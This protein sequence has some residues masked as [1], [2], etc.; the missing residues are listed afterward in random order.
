MK[1]LGV[2]TFTFVIVVLFCA[3]TL[4]ADITVDEN[5]SLQDAI[6]AANTDAEVGGCPA[7]DGADL[8]ALSADIN[9]RS[10]LPLV[11]SEITIAGDA[12]KIIG[13]RRTHIL[14][15]G[16]Q[17]SL[18]LNNLTISGGKSAWGG[19]LGNLGGTLIIRNS[20]VSGNNAE[21]GGAIGNEGTLVIENSQ[22]ADNVATS[23]GRA[24]VNSGGNVTITSSFLVSNTA[25]TSGGAI[26]NRDGVVVIQQ[27]SRISDNASKRNGGA[28]F[29]DGGSIY[30]TESTVESNTSAIGGGV[31]HLT[32]SENV[33]QILESAFVSNEATKNGG[34]INKLSGPLK[35]GNST[36]VGNSARENGGAIFDSNWGLTGVIDSTIYGNTAGEAGGGIFIQKG[37]GTFLLYSTIIAGST[38]GGDCYGRLSRNVDSLIEDGSCYASLTGDPLLAELNVPEDGSPPYLPLLQASPAIDLESQEC[39]ETDQIGTP[40]PQGEG[41]DIGAIE[42]VPGQ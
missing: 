11:N 1:Y 16:D 36:F 26:S 5:C 28:I 14:G 9:L 41:C 21:E 30:I 17:G 10:A 39:L 7:G 6:K 33:L 19:G 34:A 12:H 40:R 15:V 3:P 13:N 35:I 31:A 2:V 29:N 42:F 22:L 4:A 18:T 24:I 37:E 25:G 32:R 20:T 38:Q 27:K 23:Y 8:I